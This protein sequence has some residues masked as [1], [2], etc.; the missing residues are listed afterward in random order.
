[1]H[2]DALVWLVEDV[3]NARTDISEQADGIANLEAQ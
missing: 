3:H 2:Y 1:M